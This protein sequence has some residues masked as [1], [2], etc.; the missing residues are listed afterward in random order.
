MHRQSAAKNIVQV[1]QQAQSDMTQAD[2][3][4]SNTEKQTEQLPAINVAK[5]VVRLTSEN[6]DNIKSSVTNVVED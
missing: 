1:I 3:A 2:L 4:E 5:D 6:F